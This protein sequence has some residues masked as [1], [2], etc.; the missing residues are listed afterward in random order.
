MS[1]NRS[2]RPPNPNDSLD[3]D[4]P[5][6]YRTVEDHDDEAPDST[7][8]D[9]SFAPAGNLVEQKHS[10]ADRVST[11]RPSSGSTSEPDLGEQVHLL[12]EYED[13]MDADG[14]EDEDGEDGDGD[15]DGEARGNTSNSRRSLGLEG[16][17]G[18]DLI[19]GI[20]YRRRRQ[21]TGQRSSSIS[22]GSFPTSFSRAD[23]DKSVWAV[24]ANVVNSTVGSGILG[25]AYTL[26][27]CGLVLGVI[28]LTVT[29]LLCAASHIILATLGRYT[30]KRSWEGLSAAALGRFGPMLLEVIMILNCCGT[31]LSYIISEWA[32][33]CLRGTL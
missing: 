28:L 31:D 30:G 17:A 15:S 22:T 25:L 10:T 26:K 14:E 2:P 12:R 21:S 29:T 18:R 3:L 1:S 32:L 13:G 7:L 20:G 19:R 24:S 4:Y 33:V 16:G 6:G 8:K 27:N 9:G 5:L 11:A 23:G